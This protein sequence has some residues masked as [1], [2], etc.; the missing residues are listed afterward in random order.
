MENQK[1]WNPRYLNYCRCNGGRTP[2]E[3]L[4]YDWERRAFMSE[5]MFWI[6]DKWREFDKLFPQ[7][8]C[9]DGH[10]NEGQVQFDKWLES[11]MPEN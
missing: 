3:M 9:G 11:V 2:D 5:F 8:K 6:Q 1:E 4:K 10:S 7:Y